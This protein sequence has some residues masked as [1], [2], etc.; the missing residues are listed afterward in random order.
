MWEAALA[1]AVA[2]STL[3]LGAVV[4]YVLRPSARI[5][6]IVM[7]L[8][9]GL[10]IGSVAYDLVAGAD[11]TLSVGVLAGS[12]MAGALVFVLGSRLIERRGGKRRKKPTGPGEDVTADQPYSIVLGSALDGIPESFVLGLSVLTGGVSLPLLAGIAL[13]NMP[14]GMAASSGL[15][16]RG[17]PA[18]RALGLWSI[19][20]LVSTLS[21]VAGHELVDAENGTV[22][23]IAM[24]FA[25]GALLAMVTDTM[26]PESYEVERWWTGGLV[27]VGFS[28]SLLLGA[29]LG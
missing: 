19:V 23:G 11:V 7:A 24:T 18:R 3:L 15:R 22:T 10:L 21:A 8:G 5:T 17:W 27:V 12:L 2:S 4:A 28:A 20:V 26:I 25:A 29:W 1:G 9:S 13:S 16:A 6:A 14:E